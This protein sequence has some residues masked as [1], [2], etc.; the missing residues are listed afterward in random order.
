MLDIIGPVTPVD[1]TTTEDVSH[2]ISVPVSNSAAAIPVSVASD[3]GSTGYPIGW[4]DLQQA[5]PDGIEGYM[6]ITG[7]SDQSPTGVKIA[8]LELVRSEAGRL[9]FELGLEANVGSPIFLVPTQ[10]LEISS[11]ISGAGLSND[12]ITVFGNGSVFS[13]GLSVYNSTGEESSTTSSTAPITVRLKG[14]ASGSEPGLVRE[15]CVTY[16]DPRRHPGSE[17]PMQLQQCD[18]SYISGPII[19]NRSSSETQLWRYEPAT[20][21]LQPM[22][23]V[24]KITTEGPT[25]VPHDAPTTTSSDIIIVETAPPISGSRSPSTVTADGDDGD[26][27][28][29][30]AIPSNSAQLMHYLVRRNEDTTSSSESLE[31]AGWLTQQIVDPYS[32]VAVPFVEPYSLVFAPKGASIKQ[33]RNKASRSPA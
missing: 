2:I 27:R 17:S 18:D 1:I 29:T 13:G 5:G 24:M 16:I 15:L 30:Q 32:F 10:P 6:S 7:L 21:E 19:A 22:I 20:R 33:L 9:P 26:N 25:Q 4:P 28:Y 11:T 3:G 12:T 23:V 14:D 8:G 31:F